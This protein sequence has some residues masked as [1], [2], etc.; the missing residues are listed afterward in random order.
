MKKLYSSIMLMA[1]I[2]MTSLTLSSCDDDLSGEQ[3]IPN[4]PY[5]LSLGVTSSGNTSYY[6][7]ST[8][9]LMEG[10]I[11]AVGKGIEQN[12]YHDYQQGGNTIFC[13]GGLE[14]NSTPQEWS[15]EAPTGLLKGTR[16]I[17]FNDYHQWI[18]PSGWEHDGGPGTASN[19]ESGNKSTFYTVDAHTS[20]IT[21]KNSETF[22]FLQ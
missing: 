19:K 11:N 22:L 5:V 20:A 4:A 10:T 1:T 12:G 7:V 6:V 13:I 2:A 8:D 15:V 21:S 16:R 18:L 17:R 9:N 3:E 14:S